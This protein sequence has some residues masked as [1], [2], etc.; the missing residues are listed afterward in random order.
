MLWP[1]AS[2]SLL[3]KYRIAHQLRTP[4]GF[5]SLYHQALLTNPGIGRQSPTMAKKRN[6]RR[7]ARDQLAATVRKHF[8]SAAINENDV[9][10]NMM[11]RTRHKD[12]VF[13][14]SLGV[15]VI[16]KP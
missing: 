10:A 2:L 13:R 14:M 1:S 5:S 7:I 3:N 4:A 11:Y 12:K 15:T 16:K 6:K 8:N 9:I